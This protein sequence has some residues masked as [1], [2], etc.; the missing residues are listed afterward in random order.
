MPRPPVD[1]EDNVGSPCASLGTLLILLFFRI[2][3]GRPV[4]ATSRLST[5]A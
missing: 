5:A 3:P 4:G 2:M 1:M